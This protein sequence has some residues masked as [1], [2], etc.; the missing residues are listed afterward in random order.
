MKRLVIISILMTIIGMLVIPTVYATETEPGEEEVITISKTSASIK[1][2]ETVELTATSSKNSEI[3]WESSDSTIASVTSAGVVTGIKE[4][5]ATITARGSS[6][7]ATCS[8]NVTAKEASKFADFSEAK[9][10][11]KNSETS[12]RKYTQQE[13][14]ISN[15]KLPDDEFHSVKYAIANSK[16]MPEIDKFET[17]T[18]SKDKTE[19]VKYIMEEYV[20][21]NGDMYLWI[22]ENYEDDE[23]QYEIL[24]DAKK[25]ERPEMPKYTEFFFSTFISDSDTQIV[26]NTPAYTENRKC[27]IKIGKITDEKILKEIKDSPSQGFAQLETF[28]KNSSSIYNKKAS[29]DSSLEVKEKIDLTNKLENGSYYYMYVVMDDENGKFYPSKGLTLAMATAVKDYYGLFFYGT[30]DFKWNLK[31]TGNIKPA[32]SEEPSISPDPIPQAGKNAIIVA[33]IITGIA[34]IGAVSYH[35]YTKYRGIE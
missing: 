32:G 22:I 9:F 8:I 18:L 34:I 7:S 33:T 24:V 27:T 28:A 29:L 6:S 13:L 35:Q 17:T 26:L 20:E 23:E 19:I 10:E 1:V 25:L 21:R 16:T 5:N 30:E 11:L 31:E 12:V 2:D 3:N 15:I 4:G 14:K